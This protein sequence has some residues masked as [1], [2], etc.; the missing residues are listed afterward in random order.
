MYL[1]G[2]LRGWSGLIPGSVEADRVSEAEAPNG[3][4]SIWYTQE[5][6]LIIIGRVC[7][8]I[9]S[10]LGLGGWRNGFGSC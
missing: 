5:E 3:W 1:S 10:V 6:V 7:A 9:R 8:D 2:V 4:L